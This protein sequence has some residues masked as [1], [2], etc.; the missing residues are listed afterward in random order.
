MAGGEGLRGWLAAHRT[1]TIPKGRA[2]GEARQ[3]ASR[4]GPQ[5]PPAAAAAA[6]SAPRLPHP[7]L[8]VYFCMYSVGSVFLLPF[9]NVFYRCVCVCV[10]FMCL[11]RPVRLRASSMPAV[12]PADR[13][14]PEPIAPKHLQAPGLP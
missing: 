7:P 13:S 2:F 14:A 5:P 1:T 4:G 9:V 10:P 12:C 3:A 11:N 6:V 8:A